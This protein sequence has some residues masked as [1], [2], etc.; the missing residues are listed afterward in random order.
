M[1]KTEFGDRGAKLLRHL[2]VR[3]EKSGDEAAIRNV[4]TAAFG[5]ADEA[6]LVDRLRASGC[7]NIS[8]VATLD[9][10]IIGHILFTPVTIGDRGGQ[11]WSGWGLAPMAVLPEHQRQ[12]AGTALIDEGQ[13]RCKASGIHRIV[14]LGHPEYYPR[15]GFTPASRFGITSEYDVPDEAFMAMELAPGAFDGV[16]GLVKYHPEFGEL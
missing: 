7:D 3:A 1:I 15:F 14:V 9:G 16:A 12:H 13:A 11:S 4:V 5:Q 8:L 10:E 6:N 2:P